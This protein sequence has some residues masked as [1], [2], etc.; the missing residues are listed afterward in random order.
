MYQRLD[1]SVHIDTATH[2]RTLDSWNSKMLQIFLHVNDKSHTAIMTQW[3][4]FIHQLEVQLRTG[5]DDR[6]IRTR[7]DALCF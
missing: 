1:G 4:S 3:I 5:L 2:D 7:L 6:P